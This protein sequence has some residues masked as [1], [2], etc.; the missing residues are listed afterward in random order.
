MATKRIK[1]RN[2]LLTIEQTAEKLNVHKRTVWAHT[3]PRGL[4]RCVRIGTILRY[5]PSDVEAFLDVQAVDGEDGVI[6]H[7]LA[8]GALVM[9]DQL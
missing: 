7:L 6:E 9:A 2:Q 1:E 3:A 4:L 8:S 5:R